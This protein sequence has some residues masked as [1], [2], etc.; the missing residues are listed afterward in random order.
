[1]LEQSNVIYSKNNIVLLNNDFLKV[2]L[3]NYVNQIDLIITSPPYNVGVQ[4]DQ[5][6]DKVSY[7]QYMNF[8]ANWLTKAYNLL[9]DDGRICINVPIIANNLNEIVPL[10]SDVLHVAMQIGF[11]YRATIIWNKKHIKNRLKWGSWLSATTPY[12]SSPAETILVLFKKVWRKKK[13]G[14]TDITKKEFLSWVIGLWEFS[15]ESRIKIKHPAP[16]PVELPRRCI[17][18]FAYTTD[19]ILD[20]FSGSGTTLVAARKEQRKCIGIE[21]SKEYC[22]LAVQRLEK[23]G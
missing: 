10:S 20:P 11:K 22:N 18:L 17:R 12:I 1:M 23:E 3:S 9:K 13:R 4:Y 7:K 15:G 21:I 8:T 14:S 5:H 6:N 19:I 2:D 16:F